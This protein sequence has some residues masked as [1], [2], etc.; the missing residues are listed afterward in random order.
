MKKSVRVKIAQVRYN[1]AKMS[2]KR[3][4]KADRQA[5]LTVISKRIK[6]AVTIFLVLFVAQ[7]VIRGLNTTT[8]WTI[9]AQAIEEAQASEL[10]NPCELRDVQCEGERQVSNAPVVKAVSSDNTAIVALITKEFGD[11]ARTAIAIAKAESHLNP[12]AKGDTHI[13]FT[14]DGITMGHSCG[15]FQIRVL[16]GRPDCETLKDAEFNIKYAKEMFDR[17]GFTPWSAY[18]NGAYLKYM[19]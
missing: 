16:P 7:G 15:V 19:K 11:E 17:S 10:P 9:K 4:K 12:N 2:L 14:K 6:Q 18:K 1:K 13:E 3:E 5:M 8:V